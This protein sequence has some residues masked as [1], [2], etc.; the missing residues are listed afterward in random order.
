MIYQ[1]EESHGVLNKFL[2]FKYRY[3][4]RRGEWNESKTIS[5][6]NMR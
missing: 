3:K 6:E 4:L 1:E 5:K 2:I